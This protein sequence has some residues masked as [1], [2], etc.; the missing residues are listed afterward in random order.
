MFLLRVAHPRQLCGWPLSI[1]VSCWVAQTVWAGESL[2][3]A[4]IPPKP[5]PFPPALAG[6]PAAHPIDQFTTAK[7]HAAG[8]ELSP[9]ADRVTLLRR[10]THDL[11]G[12]APTAAEL[13]DFLADTAPNAYEK[14]V[15]RLLASPRFGEHWARHWLDLV[16]FAETDGFK[17]D[18]TR[19]TA[20]RYRD[21]VI[22]SFNNDTPYDRFLKQQIAGDELEPDN[23]DALIATGFLRLHPEETNGSDYVEVRQAI[24]DDVTDTF[25]IAVLGLTVGCARCHDHKIDPIT[26][27]DYYALQAFFAGMDHRDGVLLIGDKEA[28]AYRKQYAAW[29][30]ATQPIRAEMETLVRTSRSAVFDEV[31]ST[32]DAITQAAMHA[33]AEKR[34]PF[35]QQ[36]AMLAGKQTARR[37][38]RA[39]RR[40]DPKARARY[41]LLNA[42]LAEC[43]KLKPAEPPTT[44]MATDIGP[45]APPVYRLAG[46]NLKR[47]KEEVEPAF[48]AV[49]GHSAPAIRSRTT[50]HGTTTGRRTA[51]AEW[52]TDPAHPLTARVIVNRLWQHYFEQGIVATPSDFGGMGTPPTHPEL[53][54]WLAQDLVGH[55]WRLKSIHRLIVTSRTYQQSSEITRRTVPA[56]V[57]K[58]ATGT[59]RDPLQVDPNNDLLWRMPVLRMDGEAIRD[60]ALQSA[61]ALNLKTGGP[62]VKVPLP[63]AFANNRYG[64]DP[65]PDP[66]EHQRR[67]IYLFHRRNFVLP[68]FR[69]FDSPIPNEACP[70]RAVTVTPQ[71]T[72]ELMNGDFLLEQARRIATIVRRTPT[73]R[74]DTITA[75]YKLVLGREPT[76]R[77][78][79][80]ADRFLTNQCRIIAAETSTPV[81]SASPPLAQPRRTTETEAVVDLV[82]ALLNSA[83]FLYVE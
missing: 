19:P 58:T 68:L 79:A 53:L 54:D 76:S 7:L 3:W 4:W 69:V 39:Y 31:T 33:P 75:C 1:L 20:W 27:E 45:V 35:Q 42:K 82:H 50:K 77:E 65:D 30:T 47:P 59:V 21:Y 66:T 51:L 41:D 49:F 13:A 37:E 14:V 70:M 22:Q 61:G 73:T 18:S 6:S 29:D 48:P 83:E 64:W 74:A 60:I 10:V 5:V 80:A 34:T 24:L 15:D 55:S 81:P 78:Q 52:V 16:R 43:D 25:G 28:A 38:A 62:G 36:L 8:L 23:P 72:L 11:T 26:Q 71:Q 57:S 40:L 67:S 32:F 2:P 56:N 17:F 9:M 44:A 46:G 63:A 12:L